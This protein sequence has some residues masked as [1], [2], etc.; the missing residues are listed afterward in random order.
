MSSDSYHL[1][2]DAL[3]EEDLSGYE[4]YVSLSPEIKRKLDTAD[5]HTLS[6]LQEAV[7]DDTA[8]C[9]VRAWNNYPLDLP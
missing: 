6:E 7:R 5:I 8:N 1:N 2:L 3:I 9:E 4:Y